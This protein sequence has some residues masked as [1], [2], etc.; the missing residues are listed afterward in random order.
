MT[1]TDSFSSNNASGVTRRRFLSGATGLAVTAAGATL[2][3]QTAA[4]AVSPARR[5][6]RLARKGRTAYRIYHGAAEGLVVRQA[7]EELASYLHGITSATFDIVSA[8]EPPADTS[9]LL[10]VGRA[11]PLTTATRIDFTGLG[12]DGFA[13]RTTGSTVFIAGAHPRGTLYGAYWV[14]DRLLGV[15]WFAADATTIPHAVTLDVASDKLNGDHVPRFRYRQ[16]LAGS[17]SDPAYRQHNLLNGARGWDDGQIDAPPAPA[18][19]NTWSPYWPADPFGGNF[20]VMV[21]DQSL[22]AGGQLQCMAPKTRSMAADSLIKT[23]KERMARGEDPSFGFEQQD[24]GWTPDAAS[25]AFADQHGGALSAPVLDLVN[26]VVSRVRKQVPQARLSTQAYLFSFPPPTGIAPADGVVMTIA[27]IEAN[28]AESHFTGSNQKSGGHI[29]DWCGIAKDVVLWDYVT[30][31]SCYIQPFPDWWTVADSIRGLA[32]YPAAQGYLGQS[33]WD[34][35]GSEFVNLRV[36]VLSRLLWEPHLDVDPLIREFLKGYYGPASSLI[37]LYMR[38]MRESVNRSK[39]GLTLYDSVK[40]EFLNFD[41]MRHADVLMAR[42]SDTVRR[43]PD[44]AKRV[45]ALRLGVDYVVLM[46]SNEYLR[47]AAER[48]IDWDPDR[49][50]RLERFKAE[51]SA[52][53]LTRYREGRGTP[54][55]L[56]TLVTNMSAPADPSIINDDSSQITY[57][58]AWQVSA[59]RSLGDHNDDVHYTL[60]TGDSATI[61]FTGTGID[62]YAPKH[63]DTSSAQVTLDG[64][65]KGEYAARSSD[66]TYQPRTV[67]Y[68]VRNLPAGQHTLAVA[69]VGNAAFFTVDGFKIIT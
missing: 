13:L 2:E 66:G 51:I 33:A 68:G 45:Q 65:D 63:D 25:R 48:G 15:R 31:F 9:T 23:L 12:E 60:T 7:A 56:L 21:P 29:R 4:A 14:L 5:P 61:T 32:R 41:T 64:V 30:N 47:I 20:H 57:T 6:I 10:V 62:Y 44:F 53:G 38:L 52:A 35:R 22:W 34:A 39:S 40:A 18:S 1:S 59:G 8:D 46:R 58:G 26:D 27:P 11:N 49:D 50:N 28:F 43:H 24:A 55:E 67:I 37:Y 16:I 54:E 3:P 42:A 69:N 36:W 17:G 19:I